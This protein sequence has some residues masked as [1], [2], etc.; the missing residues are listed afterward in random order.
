MI[1]KNQKGYVL[2]VAVKM[3]MTLKNRDDLNEKKGNGSDLS[4][5]DGFY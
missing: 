5:N 3:G 2:I 1:P 4:K